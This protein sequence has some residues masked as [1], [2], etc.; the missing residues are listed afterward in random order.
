MILETNTNDV[1]SATEV[2]GTAT[3][4]DENPIV[5]EKRPASQTPKAMR[6]LSAAQAKDPMKNAYYGGF[7]N[8]AFQV[9]VVHHL[10]GDPPNQIYLRSNKTVKNPLPLILPNGVRP[11]KHGT[12]TK[13]ICS[14]VGSTDKQGNPSGTPYCQAPSM[15]NRSPIWRPTCDR[16]KHSPGSRRGIIA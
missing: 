10:P 7:R 13:V 9:G 3:N 15:P 8:I 11:P 6:M 4:I 2:Q 12:L 14:V 1:A 5:K 16:C